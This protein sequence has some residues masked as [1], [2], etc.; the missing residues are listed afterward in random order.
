M[1]LYTIIGRSWLCAEVILQSQHKCVC[2]YKYVTHSQSST[3]Q[4][5]E[6]LLSQISCGRQFILN[7]YY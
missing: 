7:Q 4:H 1:A 5:N 3:G 2:I 6:Y